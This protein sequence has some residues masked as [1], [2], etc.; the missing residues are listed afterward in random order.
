MLEQINAWVKKTD[1]DDIT[2]VD[3]FL[4]DTNK[5]ENVNTYLARYHEEIGAKIKIHDE[6]IRNS[7]EFI[8]FLEEN[9]AEL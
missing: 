6:R 9:Q 1:F 4:I 3:K 5:L 2:S 8:Q 7:M